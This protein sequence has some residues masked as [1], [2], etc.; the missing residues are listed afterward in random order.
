MLSLIYIY[1]DTIHVEL[2]I[3]FHLSA[4]PK[5]YFYIHIFYF[6][7][8][9]SSSIWISNSVTTSTTP[10]STNNK[11]IKNSFIRFYFSKC[12]STVIHKILRLILVFMC[13]S[14]LR[15]KF[16]FSRAFASINKILI[17]AGRLGNG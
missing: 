7:W 11:W 2:K 4:T 6:I 3:L 1:T 14:A 10:I 15:E 16:S 12:W 8:N 5:K 17:L 13:N 9:K